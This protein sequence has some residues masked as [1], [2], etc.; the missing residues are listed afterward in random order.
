MS[1]SGWEHHIIA[2]VQRQCAKQQSLLLSSSQFSPQAMRIRTAVEESFTNV[3]FSSRLLKILSAVV[4]EN[5]EDKEESI[6][7]VRHA[8]IVPLVNRDKELQLNCFYIVDKVS[9]DDRCVYLYPLSGSPHLFSKE[10]L[11]TRFRFKVATPEEIKTV[12]FRLSEEQISDF[13]GDLITGISL[14]SGE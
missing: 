2:Y 8:I 4:N 5:L 11:S 9:D 14:I 7:L 13:F 6:S 3:D 1:A 10:T 12:I